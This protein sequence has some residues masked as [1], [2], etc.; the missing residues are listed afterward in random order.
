MHSSSSSTVPD[1]TQPDDN[2]RPHEEAQ[3]KPQEEIFYLGRQEVVSEAS[4]QGGPHTVTLPEETIEFTSSSA[5]T[6][7][8]DVIEDVQND[9]TTKDLDLLP[10]TASTSSRP[11]TAGLAASLSNTA[12]SYPSSPQAPRPGRPLPRWNPNTVGEGQLDTF[13]LSIPG[14]PAHVHSTVLNPFDQLHPNATRPPHQTAELCTADVLLVLRDAVCQ[15]GIPSAVSEATSATQLGP[16]HASVE[17]AEA[18]EHLLDDVSTCEEIVATSPPAAAASL[19]EDILLRQIFQFFDVREAQ[20]VLPAFG[21]W[22][23]PNVLDV[24]EGW[25]LWSHPEAPTSS[26][27]PRQFMNLPIGFFDLPPS[28]G[29]DHGRR[30]R[31]QPPAASVV[32][33]H[34]VLDSWWNTLTGADDNRL[35]RILS[36]SRL[37]SIQVKPDFYCCPCHHCRNGTLRESSGGPEQRRRPLGPH[38]RAP[39]SPLSLDRLSSVD[40][41][42]ASS[43][44]LHPSSSDDNSATSQTGIGFLDDRPPLSRMAALS[45]SS[46]AGSPLGGGSPGSVPQS[47]TPCLLESPY[48]LETRYSAASLPPELWTDGPG[49]ADFVPRP[50]QSSLMVAK[51][52]A[53]AR[54][55]WI[56]RLMLLSRDTVEEIN[57][58]G[59]LPHIQTM[60]DHASTIPELPLDLKALARHYCFPRLRK[61]R[62]GVAID[63]RFIVPLLDFCRYP[64]L[65]DVEILGLHLQYEALPPKFGVEPTMVFAPQQIFSNDVSNTAAPLWLPAVYN[66]PV[67]DMLQL[68]GRGVYVSREYRY[69]GAFKDGRN[70]GWGK[71]ISKCGETYEGFWRDG[72]RY[73]PGVVVQASGKRL[74]GDWVRDV[75]HGRG[76]MQMPDGLRYEGEWSDGALDGWGVLSR[77]GRLLAVGQFFEGKPHGWMRCRT[78]YCCNHSHPVTVPGGGTTTTSSSA[79][80][81]QPCPSSSQDDDVPQSITMPSSDDNDI[82][83]SRCPFALPLCKLEPST[84]RSTSKF[85]SLRGAPGWRDM[86][87]YPTTTD[88]VHGPALRQLRQPVRPGD[89]FLLNPQH[90]MQHPGLQHHVKQHN[91]D[92]DDPPDIPE[93][94]VALVEPLAID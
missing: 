62:F 29:E 69:E 10:I 45:G 52:H 11:A 85:A 93:W 65:R 30:H 21:K 90:M 26:L 80:D 19:P 33:H 28:F 44:E 72:R 59:S 24:P 27:S 8:V 34:L 83:G 60:S 20:R 6:T 47:Q 73:G 92:T 14:T 7:L 36:Q 53:C 48:R 17:T 1:T 61:L 42:I 88:E 40:S 77:N 50:S 39:P 4:S 54:F 67:D 9:E 43:L 76:A 58:D 66:G 22:D 32:S 87:R 13:P 68:Q 64:V 15:T 31:R 18:L 2:K 81:N 16:R 35:M 37:R 79:D 23:V 55:L 38:A 41:A 75:L 74:E 84:T 86:W 12:S 25:D 46:L 49:A 94:V 3:S 57:F 82:A 70:H 5:S 78:N 63:C 56:L 71:M 89:V 51:R 91:D